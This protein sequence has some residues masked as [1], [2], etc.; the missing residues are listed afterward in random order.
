M[1]SFGEATFPQVDYRATSPYT[2][3]TW[4]TSRDSSSSSNPEMHLLANDISTSSKAPVCQREHTSQDNCRPFHSV[5]EESDCGVVSLALQMA[6]HSTPQT[7]SAMTLPPQ[8]R[9]LGLSRPRK[10]ASSKLK[11]RS[12]HEDIEAKPAAKKPKPSLKKSVL[13]EQVIRILNPFYQQQKFETKVG[14]F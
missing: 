5:P 4:L 8:R 13:A 14:D 2:S 7:Q 11:H 6:R 3:S 1:D 9:H 12:D 10:S